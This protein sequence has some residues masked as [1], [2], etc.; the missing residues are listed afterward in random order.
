MLHEIVD[1]S[2]FHAG[3]IAL[4]DAGIAGHITNLQDVLVLLPSGCCTATFDHQR[5]MAVVSFGVYRPGTSNAHARALL[6]DQ[7]H[8]GGF[9]KRDQ[10]SQ[11][12][13]G[14]G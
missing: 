4:H 10:S 3:L 2:V 13:P 9:L 7:L 6:A 8:D 5:N 14:L 1:W 11:R 12:N